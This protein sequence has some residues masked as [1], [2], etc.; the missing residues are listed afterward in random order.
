LIIAV[1][2]G[3]LKMMELLLSYLDQK[4]LINI[5]DRNGL[6]VLFYTI[7]VQNGLSI[8]KLL[9]KKNLA[10]KSL[11]DK[12]KNTVLHYAIIQKNYDAIV[13]LLENGLDIDAQNIDGRTPLM[14]AAL[15]GDEKLTEYLLEY[16]ADKVLKDNSGQTAIDLGIKSRNEK[17][18]DLLKQNRHVK[19]DDVS[20]AT[21][22]TNII[23][24][25]EKFDQLFSSKK[26]PQATKSSE[27]KIGHDEDDDDD[28][29]EEDDEEEE[30]EEETQATGGKIVLSHDKSDKGNTW[31][32]D[33]EDDDDDDEEEESQ[34]V[35]NLEKVE[36]YTNLFSGI[37]T[38]KQGLD[39]F[40]K[41]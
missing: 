16:G 18:I 32:E 31:T 13:V 27:Y 12:E 17:C 2:N 28:D 25:K 15:S 1:Q 23:K 34:V 21:E 30:D 9:F 29:E 41:K 11:V 40:K 38:E 3:N 5:P 39:L 33:D 4:N 6:S 22:S 14:L 19:S 7:R 37:Q 20:A 8:L 26:T 24:E 35:L 36:E 10:N